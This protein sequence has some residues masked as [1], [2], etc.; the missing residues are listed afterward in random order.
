MEQEVATPLKPMLRKPALSPS[1]PIASAPQTTHVISTVPFIPEGFL[2][3]G[4]EKKAWEHPLH[5]ASG[6]RSRGRAHHLQ[7]FC[8]AEGTSQLLLHLGHLV[9][10][11]TGL[12]L[13]LQ[14]PHS[15]STAAPAWPHCNPI[16]LANKSFCTPSMSATSP[17]GESAIAATFLL[18]G[19]SGG[20]CH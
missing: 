16:L 19:L 4:K 7:P 6:W 10:P 13:L 8:Q 11:G 17:L 14:P 12:L 5:P 20:K 1:F 2:L 18:P 15:D 9:P 3:G